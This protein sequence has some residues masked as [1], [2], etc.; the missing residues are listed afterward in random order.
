LENAR[1]TSALNSSTRFLVSYSACTNVFFMSESIGSKS[2]ATKR[3]LPAFRPRSGEF[4]RYTDQRTIP[5]TASG[6]RLLVTHTLS[7]GVGGN[8]GIVPPV[9]SF[10]TTE[11]T[12]HTRK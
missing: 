10:L 1:W 9:L 4:L 11:H 6:T 7:E 12:E 8:A 5:T 2:G 3:T